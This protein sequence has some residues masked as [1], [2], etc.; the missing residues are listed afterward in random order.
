M[1][2]IIDQQVKFVKELLAENPVAVIA[3]AT[4]TEEEFAEL[5]K[6]EDYQQ[7][8][9]EERQFAEALC[10][11]SVPAN[12]IAFVEIDSVGYYRFI[13]EKKNENGRKQPVGL[14]GVEIKQAKVKNNE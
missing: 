4:Y 12:N 13:A 9:S 5:R 10:Q 2:N 11:A 6:G 7:F 3:L 1:N 8:K 14:C